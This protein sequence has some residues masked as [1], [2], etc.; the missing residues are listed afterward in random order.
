MKNLLLLIKFDRL[1]NTEIIELL[2]SKIDD[3]RSSINFI[4]Y[5]NSKAVSIQLDN[6][7]I[8]NKLEITDSIHQLMRCA[9]MHPISNYD[10]SIIHSVICVESEDAL[11]TALQLDIN[12]VLMCGSQSLHLIKN[13]KK[14]T[15]DFFSNFGVFTILSNSHKFQIQS[16]HKKDSDA[17]LKHQELAYKAL[18]F[19]HHL[20]IDIK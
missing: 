3:T 7:K 10:E 8:R 17:N 6:M 5:T 15:F 19:M 12:D 2:K 11:Y 13:S 14:F 9:S 18:A 1:L 4:I 20:G 16:I